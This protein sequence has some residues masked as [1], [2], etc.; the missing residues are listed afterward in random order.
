MKLNRRNKLTV[1]E[2]E[3]STGVDSIKKL[4][5]IP[6]LP[7]A[8]RWFRIGESL[9]TEERVEILLMLV[10]NLDMFA[11][12]PYDVPRVDLSFIM[13]KL[14]VNPKVML[15]K[16]RLRRSAKPHV[17]VVKEEVEKLKQSG[18]IRE[19]FFPKW[20]ANTMVVK[21]KNGKWRVYVDFTDLN[22]ACPKDPFPVPKI[23]QL[24]DAIVKHRRMSFLDAFQGY[25]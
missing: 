5:Q 14:N 22:Q 8:N 3:S 7:Y 1:I 4:V 15:K 19:V 21:K 16:E 25:H 6:I 18:A 11:W 20:L 10:Q 23:D 2:P 13:H 9:S 17:E 12:S 24:V